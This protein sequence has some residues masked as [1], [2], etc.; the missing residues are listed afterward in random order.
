M[1][2]NQDGPQNPAPSPHPTGGLKQ[3]AFEALPVPIAILGIDAKV[4]EVNAAME[5][6]LARTRAE[7]IGTDFRNCFSVPNDAGAVL[8]RVQQEGFV[9]DVPLEVRR[10]QGLTV[11]VLVS[12][13]VYPANGYGPSGVAVSLRNVSA[14]NRIETE[15][16]AQCR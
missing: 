15:L 14:A 7:L 4:V 13:A 10:R 1:S 12:G 16:R 6:E 9:A 8:Q 5:I 2:N 11:P 3:A